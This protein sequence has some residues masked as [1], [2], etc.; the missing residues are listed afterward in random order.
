MS[1]LELNRQRGVDAEGDFVEFLEVGVVLFL[2]EVTADGQ[3]EVLRNGVV[4]RAGEAVRVE[5][6]GGRIH[7]GSLFV[8]LVLL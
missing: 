4:G 7:A 2:R 8:P 3:A 1:L 6:V 5:I